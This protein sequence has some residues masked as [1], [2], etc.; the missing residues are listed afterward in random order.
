MNN[1]LCV[2]TGAADLIPNGIEVGEGLLWCGASDRSNE[3]P[4]AGSVA[5]IL[6]A[7]VW[8]FVVE[9]LVVNVELLGRQNTAILRVLFRFYQ[10]IEI[11][12]DEFG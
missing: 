8:I 11:V 6:A 9:K 7:S 3:C 4:V 1:E 10:P 5:V 12:V 2:R